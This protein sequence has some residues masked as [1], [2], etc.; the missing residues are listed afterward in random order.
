MFRKS[1]KVRNMA[2]GNIYRHLIAYSVP[3]FLG[4]IMQMLYNIV[5]TIVVGRFIGTE[6]MA[7]VGATGMITNITLY[8]FLGFSIGAGTLVGQIFGSK[9][10]NT[11]HEAI[12]TIIAF[13]LILCV[14]F[15]VIGYSL[16][17]PILR[18]L[19]TPD[20]VFQ[21]A[22]TY[23]HI[24]FLGISG[25]IIYNIGGEILRAVGNTTMPLIFLTVSSAINI[26]LDVVF[27]IVFDAGVA[28]VAWATTISQLIAAVQ[29]LMVL[30]TT[31]EVY[32]LNWRSIHIN[33]SQLKTILSI[34]FPSSIQS[35]ITAFTNLLA[36]TYIN[37]LGSA[38]M[39]GWSC[40]NKLLGISM[41]PIDSFSSASAAFA[42]QNIGAKQF[43]RVKEGI[44]KSSIM[45]FGFSAV[46]SLGMFIFAKSLIGIFT[47]DAEAIRFGVIFIHW[48]IPSMLYYCISENLTRSMIGMSDS[49]GPTAIKLTFYVG[50]RLAFLLV[51]SAFSI[52][53]IA[54]SLA[55]TVSWGLGAAALFLYY[56]THWANRLSQLQAEHESMY[57]QLIKENSYAFKK[58]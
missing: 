52:T 14:A 25:M 2:S 46:I 41:M 49:K 48:V 53:P 31:Q 54:V 18:L 37:M 8:L 47:D 6:A 39:A 1:G 24:Y 43:S 29:V 15:T 45:S 5:D 50:F 3:I 9:E 33:S 16:S 17:N 28:G 4:R 22:S 10:K 42:S 35:V 21:F 36:Q 20:D 38:C 57:A 44:R 11:L 34:G 7:A 55:F 23:L 19:K 27:V 51:L 13:S 12:Q 32:R 58:I 56:K 40:F 30:T 26:V